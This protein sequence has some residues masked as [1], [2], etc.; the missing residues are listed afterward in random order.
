MKNLPNP[1][2]ITFF[3]LDA[4]SSIMMSPIASIALAHSGAVQEHRRHIFLTIWSLFILVGYLFRLVDRFTRVVA[5]PGA[6]CF[7]YVLF[8]AELT[9][10]LLTV[11]NKVFL[12]FLESERWP[13]RLVQLLALYCFFELAIAIINFAWEHNPPFQISRGRE[14]T[15]RPLFYTVLI[16]LWVWYVKTRSKFLATKWATHNSQVPSSPACVFNINNKQATATSRVNPIHIIFVGIIRIHFSVLQDFQFFW[17]VVLLALR[18]HNA[19]GRL[20]QQRRSGLA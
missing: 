10:C 3:P 8:F 15:P 5:I 6:T 17:S 14:I 13:K 16:D 9:G 12:C 18:F 7:A 20:F 1:F 4:N 2:I 19:Y 11:L